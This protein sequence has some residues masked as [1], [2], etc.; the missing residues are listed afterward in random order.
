MQSNVCQ[1]LLVVRLET[2]CLCFTC[3]HRG[4]LGLTG[5]IADVGSLVECLVAIHNGAA[6]FSILEKYDEKRREV[7]RTVTD[8]TSSENLKRVFNDGETVL[9]H[10]RLLQMIEKSATDP[11]LGKI[12]M[13]VR[14]PSDRV[15]K[16]GL[17]VLTSIPV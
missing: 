1:Y 15:L 17:G 9:E 16:N 13:Q 14:C 6:D 12:L 4:G 7:Y 10:D 11:A 2:Q 3:I 8:P 5:G